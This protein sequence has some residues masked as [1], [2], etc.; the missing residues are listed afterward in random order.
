MEIKDILYYENEAQLRLRNGVNKL[1]DAVKV[2]MGPCGK[3]VI[4]GKRDGTSV[5]TK[6]GVSVAEYINLIDPIENM[7]A[8]LIKNVANKTRKDVDD[9]TTTSVVLIQELLNNFFINTEKIINVSLFRNG[10]ELALNL[11][12][13]E[14]NNIKEE[15]LNKNILKSVALTSSNQDQEIADN[16]SNIVYNIGK[17]GIIDIK[18]GIQSTT[19]TI[20]FSGFKVNRGY[21]NSNFINDL[22]EN[23]FIFENDVKVLLIDD[24]LEDFNIVK[25]ILINTKNTGNAL[26]VIATEFS[27]EFIYNCEKN[28]KLGNIIIPIKSEDFNERK[29]A[30]LEDLAIYL[31]EAKVY[32]LKDFNEENL[33]ILLGD[34]SYVKITKDYTIF[35]RNEDVQNNGINKRIKHINNQL[36]ECHNDYDKSKLKERI[37]KLSSGHAIIYVGGNTK[38]EIKERFDRYEDAYGATHAAFK[39]GIL[40]GGGSALFHVHKKL[41]RPIYLPKNP[42]ELQGYKLVINSLLAPINTILKNAGLEDNIKLL[43]YNKNMLS[44]LNVMTGEIES[45]MLEAGIIDPYKVTESALKNAISVATLIISTGAVIQNNFVIQN[46]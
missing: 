21:E 20:T 32:K 8:E 24:K 10:I 45:N 23:C 29:T 12:L 22:Q 2:T 11:I 14:L 15:N 3:Y 35:R 43:K 28:F 5:A 30:I 37:S 4:L 42:T 36:D 44:G 39:Y 41:I 27:K 34:S 18:E 16:I 9:G 17:D 46:E 19:K 31:N 7:G 6:D 13:K 26:I 40:P 1:A 38:P 33:I 25:P